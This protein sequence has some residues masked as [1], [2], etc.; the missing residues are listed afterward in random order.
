MQYLSLTYFG[1]LGEGEPTSV[2]EVD[3]FLGDDERSL[4]EVDIF[5]VP[6][7]RRRSWSVSRSQKEGRKVFVYIF[8]ASR[9]PDFIRWLPNQ[10]TC[11]SVDLFIH[12]S[13]T[14]LSSDM[15]I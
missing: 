11:R 13:E 5:L 4:F 14:S 10:V 8:N 12:N 15:R 7:I 1:F 2:F 3:V 6:E 9:R